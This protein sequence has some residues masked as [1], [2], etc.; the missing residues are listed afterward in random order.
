[1]TRKIGRIESE[2]ILDTVSRSEATLELHADTYRTT[3]RLVRHYEKQLVV[4]PLDDRLPESIEERRVTLY[5][6]QHGRVL[7]MRGR[8]IEETN[9]A[10]TIEYDGHVYRS[11][12]RDT[13][14][15]IDP[16]GIG[17]SLLSGVKNAELQMLASEGYEPGERPMPSL[18][19]DFGAIQD[20][21][22]QFRA[23]VTQFADGATVVMF[24]DRLPSNISERIMARS[25]CI[26]VL[27]FYS[28]EIRTK[29]SSFG[30]R[31]L[32]RE[33][34]DEIASEMSIADPMEEFRTRLLELQT[35]DVVRELLCPVLFR[36]Y[37]VGYLHLIRTSGNDAPF[38]PDVADYCIQFARVLAYGLRLKGYFRR[39]E[40]REPQ[41]N[42]THLI[43]ISSSGLLFSYPLLYHNFLLHS[44]IELQVHF[45]RK[46]LRILGRIMRRYE[47]DTETIAYGVNFIDIDTNALE[48]LYDRLYG[49][50]YRGNIDQM[51]RVLKEE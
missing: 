11:A 41:V 37:V 47:L 34:A 39:L 30:A 40:E 18:G 16:S 44:E 5:F 12:S 10:I 29:Y 31:V 32:S 24:R 43:D 33:R 17:V 50:S 22:N 36:K 38:P 6:K 48:L 7:V 46:S 4:A 1:M 25:G 8:V 13:E 42:A 51:G 27:P 23:Q 26:V 9:R 49:T 14:R 15:I 19:F 21:Q 35:R 3:C 45:E 28:E 2:F 20:L